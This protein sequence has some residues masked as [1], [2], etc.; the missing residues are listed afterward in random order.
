MNNT[1][2]REEEYK[3]YKESIYRDLHRAFT[4]SQSLDEFKRRAKSIR[5][6]ITNDRLMPYFDKIRTRFYEYLKEREV[7]KL[8]AKFTHDHIHNEVIG[9]F[10][11]ASRINRTG[12]AFEQNRK[13]NTK[14][15]YI[16]K[17]N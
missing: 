10:R 2:L 6:R 17:K 15:I 3:R 14:L 7:R 5:R 9:L 4:I 11:E 8:T 13:F 1:F 16:A 12:S